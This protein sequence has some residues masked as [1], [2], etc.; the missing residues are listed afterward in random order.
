MYSFEQRTEQSFYVLFSRPRMLL[1]TQVCANGTCLPCRLSTRHHPQVGYY[2][3]ASMAFR[4]PARSVSWVARSLPLLEHDMPP[5]SEFTPHL[6]S[7]MLLPAS[8]APCVH[9]G[10]LM[11]MQPSISHAGAG[12]YHMH[13]DAEYGHGCSGRCVF[14]FSLAIPFVRFAHLRVYRSV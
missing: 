1:L 13:R 10:D 9:F 8:S 5:V 2:N 12:C 11:L 4:G 3:M 14:P 7:F 6:G